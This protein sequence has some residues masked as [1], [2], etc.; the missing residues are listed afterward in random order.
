MEAA[1]PPAPEGTPP[2]PEPGAVSPPPESDKASGGLRALSIVGFLVL[3][4]ACAVL[5]T[6]IV[7]I[8][9]TPTC[10]DVNAGNAQ[11]YQG[12]CFDGS[13]TKKT[14]TQILVWPGGVLAGVAALLAIAFAVTGRNGRRLLWV[15][16]L[17]IVL[18]GLGLLIGSI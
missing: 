4:F 7:D 8:G 12:H 9:H 15:L 5:I 6:A 16:A 11:P 18:S 17:A 3:A 2:P 13:T 10:S 1:P 14:I